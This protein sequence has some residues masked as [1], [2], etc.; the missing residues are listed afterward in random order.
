MD[1]KI[2]LHSSVDLGIKQSM[3]LTYLISVINFM[4]KLNFIEENKQVLQ[5]NEIINDYKSFSISSIIL[6]I[7]FFES[8]INEFFDDISNNVH[9]ENIN[10]QKKVIND[11][12]IRSV[13]YFKGE[14]ILEKPGI[15]MYEKYNIALVLAGI[16]PISK[17]ERISRE[18]KD[19]VDLR[20]E[21]VHAKSEWVWLDNHEKLQKSKTV[22]F[23]NKFKHKFNLN[24]FVIDGPFFPNRCIGLGCARWAISTVIDY[25]DEFFKRMGLMPRY[26]YLK[27]E[28]GF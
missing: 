13:Q 6:S 9:L 16:S 2:E 17:D 26:E 23:E 7:A 21:L 8:T 11:E 22:A 5:K 19:L 14:K 12:Y 20:N 27:P 24:P 15:R 25:S 28:L 10:N 1:T 3:S 4:Q 18:L